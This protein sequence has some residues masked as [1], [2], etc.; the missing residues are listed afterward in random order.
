MNHR[1][2]DII[3][4][5]LRMVLSRRHKPGD[6]REQVLVAFARKQITV[7][8]GLLAELGPERIA[9]SI[10]GDVHRRAHAPTFELGNGGRNV[11]ARYF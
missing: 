5:A 7:A 4:D 1:R 2:R 9:R 3:V 8:Q 6:S 10:G 11:V